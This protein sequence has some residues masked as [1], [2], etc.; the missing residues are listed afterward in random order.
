MKYI[1]FILFFTKCLTSL[2][3]KTAGVDVSISMPSVALIDLLSTGSN[4][5]TLKMTAPAEAGTIAGI[6][7]SNSD[8]WLIFTSAVTSGGSRSIKG[9]LI[10][11]LPPGIK[12]RL[13]I[14][15]YTGDGPGFTGGKSYVTGNVYLTNTATSFID[16]IQEAYT[17]TGYGNNGFKL[18][19][20]LEIQT[21]A[22]IRS[23]ITNV[24]VRYT[25]TD[26]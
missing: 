8:N 2:G 18:K 22:N 3:Q 16:N 20:S 26:N 24:T 6:L 10:G 25:I 4:S 14:S 21:Y 1:F 9:D 19:Y 23:G 13:D 12:L 15:P 11:T 17:G 7:N 5:V